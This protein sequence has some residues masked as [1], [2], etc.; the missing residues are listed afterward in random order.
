M[1]SN[2]HFAYGATVVLHHGVAKV[3]ADTP[4]WPKIYRMGGLEVRSIRRGH[5]FIEW[6]KWGFAESQLSQTVRHTM[7]HLRLTGH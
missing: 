7:R 3:N 6:A 5:Y 2:R 1:T 4:M